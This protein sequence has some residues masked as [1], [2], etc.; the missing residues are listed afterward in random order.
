MSF[1]NTISKVKILQSV[2]PGI[3]IKIKCPISI[4]KDIDIEILKSELK[5]SSVKGGRILR[6]NDTKI[7][8]Q[9]EEYKR[10]LETFLY[11]NLNI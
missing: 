7:R 10:Y 8:E 9:E 3:E 2:F 4:I 6:V 11:S 1:K 5:E